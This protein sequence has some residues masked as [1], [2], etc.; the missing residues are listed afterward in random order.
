MTKLD[1]LKRKSE[2]NRLYNQGKIINYSAIKIYM[3]ENSLYKIRVGIS[4]GKYVGNAVKRNR[5]KRLIKEILRKIE[6]KE[7]G[8]DLLIVVKKAAAE[9]TYHKLEKEIN[10]ALSSSFN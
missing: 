10:S 7:K 5:I 6:I 3:L 8:L 2:F 9:A 1:T 4:V